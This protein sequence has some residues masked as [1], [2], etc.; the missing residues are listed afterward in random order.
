M[1]KTEIAEIKKKLGGKTEIE[2]KIMS[3]S[4]GFGESME[5]DLERKEGWKR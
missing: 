3:V 1:I 5:R 4:A 2:R